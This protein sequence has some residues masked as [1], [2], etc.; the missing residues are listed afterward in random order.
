MATSRALIYNM[1]DIK[2][3]LTTTSQFN[4]ALSEFYITHTMTHLACGI[5]AMEIQAPDDRFSASDV[6]EASWNGSII[7]FSPIDNPY[8]PSGDPPSI[9]DQEIP[10]DERVLEPK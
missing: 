7:E 9:L 1:Q 8:P 3:E 5:R 2:D 4:A 10:L 6:W